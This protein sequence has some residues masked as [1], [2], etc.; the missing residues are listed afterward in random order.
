MIK[1]LDN[2]EKVME[3]GWDADKMADFRGLLQPFSQNASIGNMA[4]MAI[5]V[6]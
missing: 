2:V 1:L 3:H 5:G 6:F 4:K